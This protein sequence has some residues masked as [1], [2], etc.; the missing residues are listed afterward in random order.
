ME[1]EL[2]LDINMH[3]HAYIASVCM[4]ACIMCVRIRIIQSILY[5]VARF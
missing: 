4:Y 2:D 1:L 5:H 3:T